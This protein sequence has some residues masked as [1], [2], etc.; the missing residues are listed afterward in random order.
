MKN[1]KSW[2]VKV[3]QIP[4]S[5]YKAVWNG[6]TLETIR[7][8]AT[9]GEHAIKRLPP[10]KQEF[11]DVSLGTR[12]NISCPFCFLPGSNVTMS[13][14]SYKHIE[15][16]LIGDSVPT[17]NEMTGVYENN[18]VEQL[19]T[20]YYDGDIIIIETD[21]GIMQVTPSHKIFTTNRG[22]V[23]ASNLTLSD[24]IEDI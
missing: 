24:E 14:G 8:G 23:E 16:M 15:D 18:I 2:G 6:S 5:N 4:E 13:D 10:G 19:H 1:F 9:E 11:F 22:W 12:C 7:I 21:N 17:K 3:R 20:R